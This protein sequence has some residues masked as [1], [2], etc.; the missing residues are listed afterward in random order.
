MAETPV[1]AYPDFKLPFIVISDCSDVAKGATLAQIQ[2]GVEKPILYMSQA[3]NEHEVRYGISDREG[4]AAT[5]AIRSM[6]GYLRGAQVILVTDHSSLLALVKG[7]PMRS[8]RQQRYAM[9][10]SEHSLTIVHRAGPSMHLADALSRCGYGKEVSGTTVQSIQGHPFEKC[11]VEEMRQYFTPERQQRYLQARLQAA[12]GAQVSTI[13][14]EYDRLT[15]R[16]VTMNLVPEL[17]RGGGV[18]NGGVLRHGNG[19]ATAQPTAGQG[20]ARHT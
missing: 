4:C 10:L 1:L 20:P 12:G 8:M 7:G 11:N 17:V 16:E 6:R 15:Q 3:L 13:A 9:D 5:W 14:A 19:S 18:E 2:D